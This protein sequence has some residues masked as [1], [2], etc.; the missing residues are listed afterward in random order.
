[1]PKLPEQNLE[2]ILQG[3]KKLLSELTNLFLEEHIL[4]QNAINME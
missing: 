3:G 1:M 4:K 2:N